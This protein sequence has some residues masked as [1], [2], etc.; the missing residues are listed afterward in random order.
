[1]SSGRHL[2]D[3]ASVTVGRFF[4]YNYLRHDRG[5]GRPRSEAE[6]ELAGQVHVHCPKLP[7]NSV[8]TQDKGEF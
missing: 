1:M 6:L 4:Q 8:Q 2:C 3:Q 5:G 7:S